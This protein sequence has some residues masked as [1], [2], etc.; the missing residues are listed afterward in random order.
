MP[1]GYTGITK[2]ISSAMDDLTHGA[3]DP[4]A[5]VLQ[6]DHFRL[7]RIHP[8]SLVVRVLSMAGCAGLVFLHVGRNGG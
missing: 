8:K 5:D 7:H 6:G 1:G 2:G 3:G 4:L